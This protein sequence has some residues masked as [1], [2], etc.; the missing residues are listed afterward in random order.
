[1]DGIIKPV[2]RTFSV[3]GPEWHNKAEHV[4]VIDETVLAPIFFSVEERPL[5]S[6]VDGITYTIPNYKTLWADY[7]H[8]DDFGDHPKM[9]NLHVS[10][11]SYKP[12]LNR[13]I[14]EMA[15][16]AVAGL[17]CVV[18]SVGTLG[19]GKYFYITIQIKGDEEFSVKGDKF[20]GYFNIITSHNGTMALE[21]Y[22]SL[23]RIVCMNTLRWSRSAKGE[24][25]FKVY[26]T[27]NSAIAITNMGDILNQVLSGRK[28]FV[29]QMEYLMT[30]P[31]SFSQA[32][33][34]VAGWVGAGKRD[35]KLS[36]QAKNR[37][38]DIALLFR[39]GK[40]NSGKTL[41]DLLNGATEYW[42]SGNGTGKKATVVDKWTRSEF[43]KASDDKR[44]FVNYLM[45]AESFLQDRAKYGEELI[46]EWHLSQK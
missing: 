10:K 40:G 42:T 24:I 18:S 35:F 12:I 4:S 31:C 43:G 36:N 44:D 19:A 25:D 20:S 26:H 17:D 6:E 11:E 29:N 46:R 22:D 39:Q 34:L 37:V 28:E 16:K 45:G 15:L 9:V 7:R 2:D 41:Y 33:N 23:I 3:C 1:M 32:M 21:A 5:L 38:D 14:W 30:V 13:D 8:R 27:S